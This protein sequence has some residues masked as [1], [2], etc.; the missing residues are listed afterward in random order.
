M[1]FEKILGALERAYS[2]FAV[3]AFDTNLLENVSCSAR[4]RSVFGSFY[5]PKEKLIQR[6]PV[7]TGAARLT[8]AFFNSDN[9][10]DRRMFLAKIVCA[11]L[12]AL[13]VKALSTQAFSL[14]Q[15]PSAMIDFGLAAFTGAL[16]WVLFTIQIERLRDIGLSGWC[17]LTPWALAAVAVMADLVFGGIVSD[18]AVELANLGAVAYSAFLM[19]RPG[20]GRKSQEPRRS[21]Y[22]TTGESVAPC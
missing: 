4:V 6:L 13:G 1:F 20:A 2:M 22:A 18:F 16:S 5:Q 3:A 8:A 10:I 11:I 12:V 15:A 19:I 9:A 17:V 21:A 14:W 7:C